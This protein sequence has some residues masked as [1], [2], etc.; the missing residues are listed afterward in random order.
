MLC[1]V[2]FL[3]WRWM[4]MTNTLHLSSVS[5]SFCLS[6]SFFL[7]FFLSLWRCA[8]WDEYSHGRGAGLWER[9]FARAQVTG[10]ARAVIQAG[11]PGLPCGPHQPKGMWTPPHP[12]FVFYC[13]SL[14]P[15]LI[16]SQGLPFNICQAS[17]MMVRMKT[18]VYR[19]RSNM[20]FSMI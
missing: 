6:L 16:D 10:C 19:V 4:L 5:L 15:H 12:H 7:S 2:P 1:S 18:H 14:L 3:L 11:F 8:R 13:T 17:V 20:I 9:G